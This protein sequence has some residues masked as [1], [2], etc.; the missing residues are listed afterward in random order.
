MKYAYDFSRVPGPSPGEMKANDGDGILIYGTGRQQSQEYVDACEEAGLH[1]ARIWE[2]NVD[3]ILGGYAY[4]VSECLLFEANNPPGMVY[5]ACDMNNGALAG[6]DITPFL[7]GWASVTREP[8]FGLYGSDDALNQGRNAGIDKLTHNWGVVNWIRGGYANNDPRNIAFWTSWGADL[9][10]LI[11]SPVGD[12]DQNLVLNDSWWDTGD[13]SEDEDEVKPY[14]LT[15]KSNPNVGIWTSDGIF[16]RWVGPDEWKFIVDIAQLFGSPP[17]GVL[18]VSDQWWDSLTDA[19]H[20]T[21]VGAGG[22]G[23]TIGR[24][25]VSGTFSGVGTPQT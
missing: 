10:Q 25:N 3:S 7:R 13:S 22:G 8:K 5:V 18:S 20:T 23:G 17:P 12:T 2:H 16:R 24:L 15:K 1:T 6:R 14:Y 19:S 11:G 21:D 4:G 9:I